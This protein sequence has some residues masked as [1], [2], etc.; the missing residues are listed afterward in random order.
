MEDQTLLSVLKCYLLSGTATHG[1]GYVRCAPT[2]TSP[3]LLIPL[4]WLIRS[5]GLPTHP[6]KL[7]HLSQK[8]SLRMPEPHKGLRLLFTD[9]T[10]VKTMS[11]M[12]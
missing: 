9:E 12:F 10:H 2:H 5:Y 7:L 8:V 1:S 11:N 3:A 6:M 4:L